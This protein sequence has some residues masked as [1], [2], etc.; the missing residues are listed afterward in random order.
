MKMLRIDLANHAWIGSYAA[1]AGY[2][3]GMLLEL[4]L[5]VGLTGQMHAAIGNAA[6]AF[7]REIYG[8]AKGRRF[9]PLD[10]GATLMGGAPVVI[11]APG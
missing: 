7:G 10:L 2:V 11:V 9:D 4:Q 1:L 5:G 6:A 3:V 8:L